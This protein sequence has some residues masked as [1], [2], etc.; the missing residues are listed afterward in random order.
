MRPKKL[1]LSAFG[2]YAGRTEVDFDALGEKGLYLITGDTGAG[3]TTLFDAITFALYGEA[4]GNN[5]SGGMLRSKYA[6]PDTPTFV[7]LT[8]AY[9]GKDY[10]VKRNPSY[11]RPKARGEGFT[12]Q[13][14]DAELTLP[15]GRVV[16]KLKDVNAAIEQTVGVNRDQF[17]QIAMIAQGDFLKVLLAKTEERK[18]IFQKLFRT[19]AYAALQEKLKKK[20]GALESELRRLTDEVKRQMREISCKESDDL[21][22]Q[23]KQARMGDQMPE[24]EVETLLE[25]L[26]KRDEQTDK[27]LSEREAL[28]K[29]EN[30]ALVD[31][32]GKAK[33]WQI[34]LR[35]KEKK[36]EEQ[37]Q[38]QEALDKARQELKVQ[39]EKKT[40]VKE[41]S[42][43]IADVN[44]LL[45]DYAELEK[46]RG[47]KKSLS[48]KNEGIR[49]GV[50]QNKTALKR[51]NEEIAAMKEERS[52]LEGADS[53][54]T[55]LEGERNELSRKREDYRNTEKAVKELELLR[56]DVQKAQAAYQKSKALAAQKS[57]LYEE[58]RT[59]HLDGQAG[60]LAADLTEGTPCPVC[61]ST[62]HPAPARMIDRVPSKEELKGYEQE[63]NRAK[64][65]EEQDS[66]TAAKLS[67]QLSEKEKGV[68]EE[69]AKHFEGATLENAEGLLKE[70]RVAVE[71]M[72]I[73]LLER[74]SVLSEQSKRKKQIDEL[75][76]DKEQRA[77]KLKGQIGEDEKTLATGEESLKQT[78]ERIRAL[79]AKLPYENERAAK[80]ECDRL[81]ERKSILEG[82]LL[83]AQE[84][85][86]FEEKRLASAKSAIDTAKEQLKDRIDVDFQAKEARKKELKEE[87]S[88]VSS[89]RRELYR[90]KSTN[91]R[92]LGCIREGKK[93][94][95]R[96]GEDYR[97]IKSLSDTA[98]G[99][100]S[101][102]ERI[103]LETYAQ[104]TYFDRVVARSN[105]RLLVMTGGQYE[106]R[107]RE[108]TELGKQVGL[109]LDVVD[110]YNGS[111]RSVNTLS[112]GESFKASLCLA[113]GL[114]DEI[115][116]SSGGIRLDTMFVDEGFG[117]LDEESLS[118]AMKALCDLADGQR[119]VGIISHVAEL[120]SRIDRQIVVKKEQSGGSRLTVVV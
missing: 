112:G 18:E 47:E 79:E 111:L 109:D 25:V 43:K 13:S 74:L 54:K 49:R 119:L 29:E 9:G 95:R 114:S 113:L 117:S 45:P 20:E 53:E 78:E 75:L 90:Q 17:M 31:L 37:A 57:L 14:A 108:D 100:I 118:A 60:I 27:R 56:N 77:E 81:A 22:I 116:S 58:M 97:M 71:G 92:I 38:A 84:D 67:G 87:Q 19:H 80:E 102:K 107:R 40:E 3:K 70:A 103:M 12:L 120:K 46:K 105:R 35:T 85:V 115:Q 34:A 4:S 26:I 44:A 68:K 8:F 106:L 33:G 101:G 61:G 98:N 86:A 69:L 93:E 66:G 72:L 89:A 82:A 11:E 1:I 39:E 73:K 94:R 7:E 104:T 24:D 55:R 50:E 30:D 36:E 28:L 48:E 99:K 32:L 110:H 76:P 59:R 42:E 10:T 65:K 91:E 15:D 5:R 16:T 41:L 96:L 62:S 2:P 52:G 6:A 51:A 63:A 21:F 83:K 88:E 64:A 23:V